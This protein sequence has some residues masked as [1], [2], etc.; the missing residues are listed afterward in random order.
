VGRLCLI[1][2][3]VVL[4]MMM[5]SVRKSQHARSDVAVARAD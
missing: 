4:M 5:L 2:A 3:L 1:M